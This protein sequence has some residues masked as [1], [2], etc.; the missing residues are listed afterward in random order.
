MAS[1]QTSRLGTSPEEGI[2]APVKVATNAA[3]TLSGEQTVNSVAVVAGDRVLVKDQA[4][5]AENGIY[6]V[7]TSTWSRS[8]DWNKANDV[9]SGVLVMDNNSALLYRASFTGTFTAGTTEVTFT[10]IP[11]PAATRRFRLKYA[12]GASGEGLSGTDVATQFGITPIAG[13]IIEVDHYSDALTDGSGASLQATGVTTPGKAGNVPDAD[14]CFYDAAGRQFSPYLPYVSPLWFG[15]LGDGTGDD[16]QALITAFVSARENGKSL[17][18]SGRLYQVGA[19]VLWT[20]ASDMVVD[21][22]GAIIKFEDTESHTSVNVLE[23]R[24]CVNMRFSSFTVDG[25]KANRARTAGYL[26]LDNTI[27]VSSGCKN[28][29]F[30]NV[31]ARNSLGFGWRLDVQSLGDAEE[32]PPEN[33]THRNCNAFDNMQA[34]FVSVAHKHWLL[35]GCHAFG[36][37]SDESVPRF[38][39]HVERG[40]VQVCENTTLANCYGDSGIFIFNGARD[41]IVDNCYMDIA[42]GAP[43]G[44]TAL[45]LNLQAGLSQ[46]AVVTGGIYK[47]GEVVLAAG[48][49][50]G[51]RGHI[52][53]NGLQSY[54]SPG[55][56]ITTLTETHYTT[57][58][59]CQIIRPAD[60]GINFN[61][62]DKYSLIQGCLIEDAGMDNESVRYAIRTGGQ[63]CAVRSCTFIRRS[64][65][66]RMATMHFRDFLFLFS[67]NQAI[68]L[69]AFETPGAGGGWSGITPTWTLRD[70]DVRYFPETMSGN[71]GFGE[72]DQNCLQV[73]EMASNRW[74]HKSMHVAI[75]TG[76][77]GPRLQTAAGAP[78]QKITCVGRNASGVSTF[79]L[80]DSGDRYIRLS[81]SEVTEIAVSNGKSFTCVSDGVDRWI[82]TEENL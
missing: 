75:G 38:S 63:Q 48:S 33:I 81:G 78:G 45:Q 74:V 55:H 51:R 6:V 60:N 21:G 16:H 66:A 65:A 50:V 12:S 40:G 27:R 53:V 47:G 5:A 67:D 3:I 15:A 39:Y 2:K 71:R 30:D 20:G 17:D 24:A 26:P 28:V 56:G 76:A 18:L 23:L 37:F 77:T 32:S 29:L 58:V 36:N 41:T 43:S 46:R 7:S 54:D 73:S 4:D 69:T 49:D 79:R 19:R 11:A 80:R 61:D 25:N 13:D 62:S 9:A 82:I 35:E 57:I 1:S 68:G 52:T 72:L 42:E 64:A 31:T 34:G 14:G 22:N 10:S 8:T 59:N 70:S 44:V